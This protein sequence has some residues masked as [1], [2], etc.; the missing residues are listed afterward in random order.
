MG[1]ARFKLNYNLKQAN[2]T[3]QLSGR[4]K[5]AIVSPFYAALDSSPPIERHY[6]RQVL[7]ILFRFLWTARLK[8]N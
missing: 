8:K 7:S 1:R 5:K 4:I 3:R 6:G 2:E